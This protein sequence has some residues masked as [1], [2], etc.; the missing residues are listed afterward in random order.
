MPAGQLFEYLPAVQSSHA[1]SCVALGS[2]IT[3][4]PAAHVVCARHELCPACSWYCPSPQALHDAAPLASLNCPAGQSAQT[5][6]LP[7]V[8]AAVSYEPFW[9]C[10]T[11]RHDVC[12]S[13][14]WYCPA[15][16]PAHVVLPLA[17]WK[18]GRAHV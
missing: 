18:I 5:R 2:W 6:S 10:C 11:A 9:H 15:V 1:R 12:P 4:R 17:F 8:G 7:A 13:A 14:D 3:R 16:Q